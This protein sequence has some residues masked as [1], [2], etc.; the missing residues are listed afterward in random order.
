MTVNTE[1]LTK[2]V[3]ITAV[4]GKYTGGFNHPDIY[5]SLLGPFLTHSTR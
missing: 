5:I 2:M 1:E 4:F 3:D